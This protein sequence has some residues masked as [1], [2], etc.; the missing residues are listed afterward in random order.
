MQSIYQD[1]I[2]VKEGKLRGCFRYKDLFQIYPY[3]K[4]FPPKLQNPA[5][6]DYLAVIEYSFECNDFYQEAH[7]QRFL[8]LENLLSLL[9]SLLNGVL[10]Q[11]KMGACCWGVSSDMYQSSDTKDLT[12]RWVFPFIMYEGILQNR[13]IQDFTDVSNLNNLTSYSSTDY[14]LE[15]C[16]KSDITHYPDDLIDV[17]D[18][19]YN[20]SINN[21]QLY[22]HNL[23]L[24]TD[25]LEIISDKLALGELA[26][27][28]A[29]EGFANL[30]SE[31]KDLSRSKR[32]CEYLKKYVDID[33]EDI[34]KKLYCH[35]GEITHEGKLSMSEF[36]MD[37]DVCD[38]HEKEWTLTL[39]QFYRIA[40]NNMLLCKLF[41]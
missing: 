11:Y 24:A 19:F 31:I 13:T 10:F 23:R 21:Q 26:V 35:R 29:I 4:L 17:L 22:L 25:G 18:A 38:F 14:Y 5:P 16:G 32:F 12:S 37:W 9:T 6:E 7:R 30:E 2:A 15:F 34:Y 8:Y 1:V 36:Q 33:K 27:F 41:D 39:I 20:L 40:L 3:D 28:S